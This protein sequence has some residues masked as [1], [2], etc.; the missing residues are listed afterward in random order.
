MSS[1]FD[2]NIQEIL[3]NWEIHHALREIISNALD[4]TTI[5]KSDPI[6]IYKDQKGRWHIRDY[7]RG[8]QVNCLTQNESSEKK[9]HSNLIG[10]FGVGLKDAI[11]VFHDHG[12][13]V[14]IDSKYA[15]LTFEDAPKSGFESVR[16]LH[17]VVDEPLDPNMVGTDVILENCP[18][19]EVEK[20]K[21]LFLFFNDE[22]VIG[23]TADGSILEKDPSAPAR[24]Y[25]NGLLI[26]EE[27]NFLFSYNIKKLDS[28]LRKALNRERMNIGRS[29]VTDIIKNI[30]LSCEDEE[31]LERLIRAIEGFD[32]ETNTPVE[33]TWK[34]VN[35][36]ALRLLAQR[37]HDVVL[38]SKSEMQNNPAL[39]DHVRSMGKTII[40][41][42]DDIKETFND[43]NNLLG[44]EEKIPTVDS[45][46]ELE[47]KTFKAKP[48]PIEKLTSEQKK[49]YDQT[50][51]I[52]ELINRDNP[53]KKIVICEE[54][55]C[56][57]DGNE[58][59]YSIKDGDTLNVSIDCLSDFY[60]YCHCILGAAAAKSS[61]G[62]RYESEYADYVTDCLTELVAG[63]L[64]TKIELE[65][66]SN[67]PN[68]Q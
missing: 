14:F 54:L 57:M 41:V 67:K 30:L 47:H 37:K 52:F 51:N 45:F 36:H 48:V 9:A 31:I 33:L 35:V 63:I 3:S 2:L 40:Q 34:A 61:G 15:H 58:L 22:K 12:I 29:A 6:S 32:G 46:I 1:L 20:A 62:H 68:N 21:S 42:S 44:D 26:S 19:L 10:K 59:E 28:K 55:V 11:G 13:A 27:E 65:E 17:A 5:S 24:I 18:D 53:F 66:Q 64:L 7:G 16:T 50:E 8:L 43:E 39:V 38:I 25:V 4:E 49:F 56:G 60:D 23:D